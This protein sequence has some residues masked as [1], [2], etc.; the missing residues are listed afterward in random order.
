MHEGKLEKRELDPAGVAVG[1]RHQEVPFD[2][3]TGKAQLELRFGG[4]LRPQLYANRNLVYSIDQRWAYFEDNA[5]GLGIRTSLGRLASLRLFVEQGTND[6]TAL[7]SGLV[8]RRDDLD[9]FGGDLRFTFGRYSVQIGAT[10][11]KYDS[12]LAGFDRE[13][14][15]I[16]SGLGFGTGGGSPWG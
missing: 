14:T 7:G 11:T 3:V 8:D 10:R 12:N 9:V 6:Y 4:R 2:E 15:V 5:V 13:V 16:R 1:A